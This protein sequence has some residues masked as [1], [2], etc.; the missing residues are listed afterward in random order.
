MYQILIVDDEERIRRTFTRL[1]ERKG[2]KVLVASKATDA[3]DIIARKN[4]NLMLLD[5]NMGKVDGDIL[6]EVA[7]MF[8]PQ[9][10]IIVSSVYPLE[11][12]Y[13]LIQGADDYYDKSESLNVLL[14]KINKVSSY[15]PS[16]LREKTIL[17]I[18]DDQKIRDLYHELFS[19][20]GYNSL[21]IADRDDV[22]EFLKKKI[23]LIILD[24]EM[25]KV[26]G[27]DFFEVIKKKYPNTKVI[28]SSNYEVDQQEAQIFTA[29][30]YYDKSEGNAALLAKIETIFK[31]TKSMHT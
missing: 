4:V 8:H 26:S 23:D 5:I 6:F 31:E 30:D 9:M 20:A 13:E 21:E 27:I 2:Y 7:H 17:V 18:D 28:I 14:K 12:Q 19:A 3:K 11:D 10:K 25:P 22:F 1:L 16:V 15:D 24:L 29:D